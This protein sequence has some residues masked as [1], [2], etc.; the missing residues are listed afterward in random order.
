MIIGI[1][2]D[3]VE[4]NRFSRWHTYK[5]SMLERIFTK[6]EIDYCLKNPRLSSERFAA[7][8]ASKEALYKALGNNKLRGTISFLSIARC[9]E[10]KKNAN[11]SVVLRA[12]WDRILKDTKNVC[13][14]LSLTHT[15]TTAI[16]WVILER[17]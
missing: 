10:I 2:I 7:R 11:G 8:F 13:S 17:K 1:G 5:R 16:A 15:R 14:W 4:I 12:P 3:S 6:Q 9:I